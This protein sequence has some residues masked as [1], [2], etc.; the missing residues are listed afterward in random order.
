MSTATNCSTL[1]PAATAVAVRNR[2]RR[3]LEELTRAA[4][5]ANTLPADDNGVLFDLSINLTQA[6]TALTT[7]IADVERYIADA[8]RAERAALAQAA[9]DEFNA[10]VF[11]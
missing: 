3:D 2:L 11:A 5:G 4:A 10:L 6:L 7:A 1:S 8:Q 9:A